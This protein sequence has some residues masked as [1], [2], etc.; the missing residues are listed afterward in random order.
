MFFFD[1]LSILPSPGEESKCMDGRIGNVSQAVWLG[2]SLGSWKMW[3]Q[4]QSDERSSG[5][6]FTCGIIQPLRYEVPRSL[7]WLWLFSR[8]QI[9]HFSSL[10]SLISCFCFS[11]PLV[12]CWFFFFFSS[13]AA[14]L[15]GQFRTERGSLLRIL[16]QTRPISR[17][18]QAAIA[19][20]ILSVSPLKDLFLRNYF[21]ICLC[22]IYF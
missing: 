22:A 7:I 11:Y 3:A 12:L 15:W 17:Q 1:S 16:Q 8:W 9:I 14:V 4:L 20:Y 2:Q 5:S 18:T 6:S 10:A 21:L 19:L 13:Q